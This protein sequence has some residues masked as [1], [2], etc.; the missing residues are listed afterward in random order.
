VIDNHCHPLDPQKAQLD[1]KLLVREFY[2]GFGDLPQTDVKPRQWGISNSLSHHLPYLGIVQTLIHQLSK[3]LGCSANLEAVVNA[4][5]HQTKQSLPEYVRWLYDEAQ[6]VGTVLDSDLPVDD[7][8]L[9]IFP[10]RLMRLFQ[11]SPALT[12]LLRSSSSYQELLASFQFRLDSAI[13][14]HGYVG[15]K[16]HLAEE[17]GF[18][19]LPKPL[20]NSLFA[21][22][23]SGDRSAYQQVYLAVFIETL[24]QCQKLRIPVHLHTG[25]TGGL[26]DGP[27]SDADPFKIVSLLRQPEFIQTRVVL[28]HGAYPWI[29]HAAAVAHALPHVW[30]DLSW[31]TPWIAQRIIECYRDAIGMMPLSKLMIGSGGHGIPE[32][33][34]LAAKTAKIALKKVLED[35]VKQKLLG[36][37]QAEQIGRMILHDNAAHLYGLL[38]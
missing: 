13:C 28:L 22:A 24:R 10:G 15:V 16:A 17:V 31:T 20:T 2:H 36:F 30:V 23:K 18:G 8:I 12:S 1:S 37:Q 26:W 38:K 21:A 29:Q 34:W 27:V 5:N 33:A 14:H 7:P 35:N 3:V 19:T 4:R 25:L 9:N 6:I 32:I 11:M